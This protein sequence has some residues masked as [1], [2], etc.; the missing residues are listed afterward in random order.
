M[1]DEIFDCT[2]LASLPVIEAEALAFLTSS[3][4]EATL[5]VYATLDGPSAGP[6]NLKSESKPGWGLN[7]AGTSDTRARISGTKSGYPYTPAPQ[8][9]TEAHELP[10][11]TLIT[12]HR[13]KDATFAT[14][15]KEVLSASGS[16]QAVWHFRGLRIRTG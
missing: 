10:T 5:D 11:D 8:A 15:T 1:L 2:V 3:D 14:V 7:A 9:Q 12:G 6:G 16:T 13:M 4:L